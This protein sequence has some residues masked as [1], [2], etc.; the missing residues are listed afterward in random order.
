MLQD[1]RVA[2]RT[3]RKR[4]GFTALAALTLAVGIGVTTAVFSLVQGV[5]LTPPPYRDPQTL[6]LIPSVRLDRQ[7]TER[8]DRTLAIQWLDWQKQARSFDTIAAYGW[9]FNFLVDSNNGSSS[10][11]G[12]AVTPEYF[13]LVGVQPILGRAFEHSDTVPPA[14][15]IL[16]GYDLW[17]RRF[18]GNPTIV[19]TTLRISRFQTPVTVIGVMPRGIRFLPSPSA[20]Q[21]PNY[22][23]NATVD[24]WM[25]AAP[26]PD[27]LKQSPWDVVGRLKP[28]VTPEHAQ[29]ELLTLA[30]QQAQDDPDLDGRVPR[31]QTF[32]SEMNREGR[33]IL[34]PL[35]GAALLVL[36][37]ACGNTAAL[38]LVRGLQRQH[39]YAVRAALGSRRAILFRQ[40][41]IE[42]GLIALVGGTVGI[43]IATGIVWIFKSIGGHAIPR[44]DAV[45]TGW[46]LLV[47]GL[48]AAFFATLVACLV[49]AVRAS[50][51]DASDALKQSGSRTS[52]GRAER[53]MLRAVTL[54]QT[55]LTLALLVGAGLLIRTLHNVANVPAGYSLN[56]VLTMTVTAV[57]GNWDDFHQRALERVSRAPGVQQAA[58]AWGTPLTGNDWPGLIEIEGHPAATLNDRIALPLRSVTPGYFALLELPIVDG[59][60]FRDSDKRGA[61]AVAIVNQT[62]AD[63]YFPGEHAIGR[64]IWMGPRTDAGIQIVGVV[65]NA[66]TSDLTETP[67]PEV[68]LPLWQANAFSK[69]LVVKTAADPRSAVAAIR[70]ELRGV[71]PTVAVEHVKTLED[72]RTDSLASR[73]FARQLL[74]GFSAI[75]TLLTVIGVYGVLALSIAS[76]RREIAIRAAIGAHRRDIRNL[77]LREGLG[78]VAAGIGVGILAALAMARMLASFLYGVEPTDSATIVGAG[79]LFVAVTILACWMP[80][81][82]AAAIDPLEALKCE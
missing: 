46:P 69:D 14:T 62:L 56:R 65:A 81:R 49:P 5:L 15:T 48:A 82:R 16:L 52:A 2:V 10:L 31:V 44:L 53:R 63:R 35:F 59:R 77:V 60:D 18:N 47:G 55:A 34:L 21:E 17:Q 11:E 23:V 72:I 19:G 41:A 7:R 76:R 51:L 38:L 54:V 3:L 68:Y 13:G 27:R 70:Q 1:I 8:L 9:S 73:V 6:V 57:Q 64:R 4:P 22:D 45:G 37:I 78:L 74:V 39:E 33:R 26:N 66:R 28:G 61:P 12:M 58:F 36:L 24:F 75:G 50:D 30:R 42:S 29:A 67:T 40:A 20:S 43:G 71:D 79:V 25:P 32:E 80:T